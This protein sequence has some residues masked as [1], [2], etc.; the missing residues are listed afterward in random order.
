MIA[1]LLV[2]GAA[3]ES[4]PAD[5]FVPLLEKHGG[6]GDPV[7]DSSN[8]YIGNEAVIALGKKLY[9]DPSFSG[10]AILAERTE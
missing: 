1:G 8:K 10:K 3:C 9:F 6:L 7:P 2:H 4:E 5:P